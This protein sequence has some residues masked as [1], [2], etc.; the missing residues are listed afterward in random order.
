MIDDCK[1]SRIFF[2]VYCLNLNVKELLVSKFVQ[3][4]LLKVFFFIAMGLP[5][6]KLSYLV[7]QLDSNRPYMYLIS[8]RLFI[9]FVKYIRDFDLITSRL[10]Y[11]FLVNSELGWWTFGLIASWSNVD[12]LCSYGWWG[13]GKPH[14]D[15]LRLCFLS[16]LRASMCRHDMVHVFAKLYANNRNGRLLRYMWGLICYFM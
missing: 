12:W 15:V 14:W 6:F 10:S 13:F 7:F 11:L 8:F 1:L 16:S 5:H 9:S 3:K 2:F 4:K